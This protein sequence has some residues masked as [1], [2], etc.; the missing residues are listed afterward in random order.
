[1]AVEESKHINTR[2]AKI[3]AELLQQLAQSYVTDRVKLSYYTVQ[4]YAR[5]EGLNLHPTSV[6]MRVKILVTE[7]ARR[8]GVK[9]EFARGHRAGIYIHKSDIPRLVTA[10]E[11]L[12]QGQLSK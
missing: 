1:M 4:R 2:L 11:G 6:A 10:L 7:A 8:A 12:V 3:V 9:I 5:K